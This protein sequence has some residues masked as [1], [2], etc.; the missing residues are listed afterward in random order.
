MRLPG[1]IKGDIDP[2]T[3]LQPMN[4][5]L[6]AVRQTL[7]G[8]KTPTAFLGGGLFPAVITE[9]VLFI[10]AAFG[11]ILRHNHRTPFDGNA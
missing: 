10:G 2:F 7:K 8:E 5:V 1:E 11:Y 3:I 4:V 9:K 6:I